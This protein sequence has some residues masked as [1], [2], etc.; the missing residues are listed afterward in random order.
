M[1]DVFLQGKNSGPPGRND[2]NGRI[3]FIQLSSIEKV[4]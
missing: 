4:N 3:F 1:Q 2:R